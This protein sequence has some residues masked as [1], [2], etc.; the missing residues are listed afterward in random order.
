MFLTESDPISEQEAHENRLAYAMGIDQAQRVLGTFDDKA[1]GVPPTPGNKAWDVHEEKGPVWM[2]FLDAPG[3][4]D[5]FYCSLLAYSK[6]AKCLAVALGSNVYL[7]SESEGVGT[8]QNINAASNGH[9]TS[10][11]F[12]STEGSKGILAIGRADG[13]VTLWSVFEDETRFRTQQPRPI[14]CV[15]FAPK[16]VKRSSMRDPAMI[17]H[18]EQLL[19]GDEVGNVFFFSVEWPTGTHRD[20]FDWP[21]AMTLLARFTVHSQQICGLAWS[22]GGEFFATGGNDNNCFLFETKEVLSTPPVVQSMAIHR[23]TSGSHQYTVTPSSSSVPSMLFNHAK[24]KW[25]L[26]AAVKAIAFCPWQRG[27][28]AVGGGSNDRCIHFYHTISG[29]CLATIDC[30]AQVT[31][32]IWSNTRREICA[33]FGFAQ[34]EHSFRIAVFSWPTCEQLVAIPWTEEHRA[35]YAIPYPGGPNDGRTKGEGGA[36]CS[37]TQVEGCIVVATSDSSIKF[38]EVWSEERRLPTSVTSIFGG[39]EILGELHGVEKDTGRT[40]R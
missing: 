24:H 21:G 15:S 26:N 12:S 32:L 31:G 1:Y 10:L 16:T 30:S 14:S 34:P 23:T 19:I 29:A 17:I 40:I 38:H 18:T 36:W 3:L 8:P 5:D 13:S 28:L 22:L 9:V 37:R 7:W 11:S 27:L 20:L 25:T 35:L 2:D 33:T 6:T 39:S 4:R